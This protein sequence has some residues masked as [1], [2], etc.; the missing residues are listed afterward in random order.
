MAP[1]ITIIVRS[2]FDSVLIGY[3]NFDSQAC[4][5]C[6]STTLKRSSSGSTTANKNDILHF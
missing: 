1:T 5:E 3:E 6:M 4:Q 2:T